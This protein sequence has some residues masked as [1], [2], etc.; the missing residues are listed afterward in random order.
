MRI[1]SIF[2]GVLTAAALVAGSASAQTGN[3]ERNQSNS[4]GS[5]AIDAGDFLAPSQFDADG[6]VYG[7]RADDFIASVSARKPLKTA[8]LSTSLTPGACN[9]ATNFPGGWCNTAHGLAASVF[10]WNF[11][12]TGKGAVVGIVDSGIDLNNA[13]FAGRILKGTCIVSGVNSCTLADD[14]VGGDDA[15]YNLATGVATHGTHVAGIAT[16]KNV[17]IASSASI[18]P[19]KVCGS[20]TESCSGVD[21]GIVWAAQHGANVINVSIGG[22][23]LTSSSVT[24]LKTA[25]KAGA[26]IVVAAGNA[27]NAD[28]TGGAYAAGA[29]ID[30]IRGSMIVVGAT[31]CTASGTT[32]VNCSN[33]GKGTIASF[34]QE[35]G[36]R[37]QVSGGKSVCMKDYFVV[38]PGLDI[39]SSVGNGTSTVTNYG[40]LSGTSMATPYVTGVAAVIKG[41]WP[42][43]TSSQIA[44]IIFQTTDDIGA[45]GVDPVYGRG[46]V[47]IKKALGP[48]GST[49]VATKKFSVTPTAPGNSAGAAASVSG[50]SGDAAAANAI[51]KLG[52]AGAQKSIVSGAMSVALQNSKLLKSAVLVDSFG[53]TFNANLTKASYNPGL[54]FSG[55]FLS[56]PFTSYAPFAFAGEGP[57]GRF[58]AS[59]YAVQS[60]TPRLLSGQFLT[61]DQRRYTVRDLEFSTALSDG[62]LL[63]AGYN[64]DLQGRFNG[65][66]V[67]GS[68][69]Y[70]GLFLSGSALNSPY[71]SFTNGGS[72]VGA[73]IALASDLRLN[74]GESMLGTQRDEFEVPVFSYLSQV[75][76]PQ[77]SFD[78][79][80][81]TTTMAGMD[82][83]FASW[84]GLG[85]TA[86]NT[87]E[88]HGMLGG[89][90][91]GALA[92][93]DGA[94]TSALGLSARVGFGNGWVTTV[95]YSE[96]ITQLDLRSNSIASSA[97]TLHSRAYGVAIAKHGL[98]ADNDSLG[99]AV[100]RPIQVY[101]GG[102]GLTLGTGLDDSGNLLTGTEHVSL[103]SGTP[104]TDF[105]MGYVTTFFDG[106]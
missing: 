77:T 17:G 3:L 44:S 47:D 36:N 71:Q 75:M 73:T 35:P 90:N 22:G 8:S 42:T 12:A 76:G 45:L 15:T 11:S 43:L 53:R 56:S 54:D 19:V 85:V 37:C 26:L 86:S 84:G 13:E 21:Q 100:S 66:D 82:W 5:A 33:G 106:A 16:G 72:F 9:V 7:V 57:L 99:L 50:L 89:V 87:L 69:A 83:D 2:A 78:Q 93:A 27:G 95:S 97:D 18:L 88:R 40:Y 10:G 59:G 52:V 74:F 70:D 101:S 58:Q 92:I 102:L 62:V 63:N 34:S 20:N 41:N 61:Q 65:Y 24:A 14:K 28:P 30:G 105:E 48:V 25:V 29:L 49:I 31:G 68:S 91:S 79:R 1:H 103:V 6:S 23:I 81:A 46:E 32:P 80:T 104:E 38:A 98:F 96:G 60:V 39:W 55:Y 67:Q 51:S 4:L 94:N 64:L